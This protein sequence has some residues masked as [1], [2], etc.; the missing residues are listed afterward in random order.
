MEAK[1]VDMTDIRMKFHHIVWITLFILHS[2]FFTA[3]AYRIEISNPAI[4][5]MPVFLA[6]YYGDHLSVID[7]VAA[8]A[9]GK[10]VFERNYDLSAGM[11]TLV[12]PGKLQYDLLIDVGQQLWIEWLTTGDV[13]IEGDVQTAAWAAY[14]AWADTNPEREQLTER[15]RQI[16]SQYPDAF[17]AAYL[18]ALQPVE[19]PDTEITGD[20][21]QLMNRYQYS[22]RHYFDN[23]PLSDVRLLR[24]PLYHETIHYYITKFV[25]QQTDSL[26]HIAYRMLEQ[27]SGNYETFFYVS[28]FLIDFSLR[29]YTKIKDLNKL[30]N[31]V[32]RNRD[33]LGS[34]GQTMLSN[35]SNINYFKIHDEK[36]LQ[37]RLENMPLTD[38]NGQAFQLQTISGKYRVFYFWQ[39]DC[40]RCIADAARWQTILNKY[41]NKSC[42]GIA[43]NVKYDVQ[44]QENRILAFDPLCINVSAANAPWCETFF[45]TNLYSKIVV[46]DADGNIIGIFASA[47]ALDNFLRIAQ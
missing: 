21:S 44:Q 28:D 45:F 12:A 15:R 14:Q 47:A 2:S 39:N 5:N 16:I 3:N 22:R 26:I 18:A 35:R 7:S 8:D 33:I 37:K 40:P 41:A 30:Y 19:P 13:R 24:T 31:F 27:A 11:Y 43:V 17:L 23:R 10:A 32:N 1:E 20:L 36:L 38:I 29:N 25:T 9:G 34:K 4:A 6:A 46:T 42:S